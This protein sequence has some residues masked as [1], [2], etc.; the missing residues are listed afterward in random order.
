M[1]IAV[2]KKT[3]LFIPL[4]FHRHN[5]VLPATGFQRGQRG[6]LASCAPRVARATGISPAATYPAGLAIQTGNS[7]GMQTLDQ[8]LADLVR[9]NMISPAEARSKAKIP[10]NFPG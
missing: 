3:S 7:V 5:F 4:N 2:E 10:E 8:N 1:F 9:R 6:R